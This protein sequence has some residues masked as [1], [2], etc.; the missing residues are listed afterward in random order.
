LLAHG[1]RVPCMPPSHNL[2]G[3][4]LCIGDGTGIKG[5]F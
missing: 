1:P 4:L 2:P 5:F 3:P